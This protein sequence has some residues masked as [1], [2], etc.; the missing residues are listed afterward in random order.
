MLLP[1]LRASFD[2]LLSPTE[3]FDRVKRK[4]RW[5]LVPFVLAAPIVMISSIWAL[6]I[7]LQG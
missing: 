7:G 3:T 4:N 1:T 2:V 6:Y 5:W